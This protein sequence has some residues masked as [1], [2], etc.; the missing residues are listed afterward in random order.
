MVERL[1]LTALTG[2]LLSGLTGQLVSAADSA[3]CL[4]CHAAERWNPRHGPNRTA[5]GE[6]GR[7]TCTDCH[8]G[9]AGHLPNPR[10]AGPEVSFGPNHPATAQLRADACSSCHD[11]GPLLGWDHSVHAREDVVC[12]DC[13]AVH[14]TAAPT[15]RAWLGGPGSV[16]ND[17]GRCLTCHG[18]LRA[19][20]RAPSRHPI[21]EGRTGCTDCHDPHGGRG[22]VEL[23]EAT[24]N[25]QCLSCHPAQRGPWLFD[26][27]PVSEDCQLCHTAHGSMHDP[28]LLRRSP[29]L[30]QDCHVAEIHVSMPLGAGGLPGG[31]AP[32]ASM[33][34]RDCLNCHSKVHGTNH[35]AGGRLTR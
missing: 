18:H 7:S 11:S 2:L 22:P 6:L 10:A 29:Q 25:G 23:R 17:D 30:C 27:P 26:H 14:S 33:L 31:T 3:V 16:D 13:H 15:A 5:E 21:L 9:L 8:G 35:P 12:N 28:L 1:L 19:Q 34:G 20:L 4:N 32:S 24:V